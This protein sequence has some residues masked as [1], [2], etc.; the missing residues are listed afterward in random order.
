MLNKLSTR[1]ALSFILSFSMLFSAVFSTV[2]LEASAEET[3]TVAA[4]AQFM[5]LDA[6]SD[7]DFA[8]FG[9]N[10]VPD[11]TVSQFDENGTYKSYYDLTADSKGGVVLNPNAWWDKVPDIWQYFYCDSQDYASMKTLGQITSDS[12]LSHTADGS[13]ALILKEKTTLYLPIP[14]LEAQTYYVITAWVNQSAGSGLTTKIHDTGK[15]EIANKQQWLNPG[16]QRITWIYYTGPVAQSQAAMSVYSDVS[17]YIDDIEVYALDA[18]YAALCKE[19]GKILSKKDLLPDEVNVI[20]MTYSD[21]EYYD[22]SDI[23]FAE[24]GENLV[25]DST[26]SQFDEN[27]TYTSYYDLASND[28]G[29]VVLN[30]NAWWDKVPNRYQYFYNNS[31][32]FASMKTLGYLSNDASLSH[33]ADGSGVLTFGANQNIYLPLPQLQDKTYYLVTAWVNQAED[34]TLT[35]GIWDS[36]LA[37]LNT[38]SKWAFPSGWQRVS[39]LYYTGANEQIQP[40]FHM[41]TNASG[42]IDDVAVYELDSDYAVK[43]I[44]AGKLV[45]PVHKMLGDVNGDT[46][47][48]IKDLIRIKKAL[49]KVTQDYIRINADIDSD[50]EITAAD[51]SE[52]KK[53]LMGE[54]ISFK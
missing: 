33:T 27:G 48:N 23:D 29:E 38:F 17:G 36:N 49:A 3:E 34:I 21:T 35:T 10:L 30:S 5:E 25:P 53:Y 50:G 37:T 7:V 20:Q 40:V 18:D 26:V 4:S 43:C 39:W 54:V 11:S 15:N 13:G 22:Y 2:F 9:T 32:A 45:T 47:I 31:S 41:Y 28:K 14:A 1:K 19:A 12:S 52:L 46:L 24:Y 42:Y 8:G 44:N 16:W 6:Y 51:I